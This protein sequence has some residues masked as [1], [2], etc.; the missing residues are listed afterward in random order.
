MKATTTDTCCNAMRAACLPACLLACL[1]A[2]LPE[3]VHVCV[4][5]RVHVSRGRGPLIPSLWLVKLH[6]CVC[7]CV[8][9]PSI[10]GSVG[11]LHAVCLPANPRGGWRMSTFVHATDALAPT[12]PLPCVDARLIGAYNRASRVAFVSFSSP[13]CLSVCPS[14]TVC[15]PLR[16]AVFQRER[17]THTVADRQTDRDRLNTN[18]SVCLSVC[19]FVVGQV[20]LHRGVWCAYPS[21]TRQ[22]TA[23]HG[24]AFSCSCRPAVP[25]F[26]DGWMWCVRR[27]LVSVWAAIGHTHTHTRTRTHTHTH[28]GEQ[29]PKGRDAVFHSCAEPVCR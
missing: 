5:V 25:T 28:T 14:A 23:R 1:P 26:S 17:G 13:V 6:V 27:L 9:Y 16:S 21:L 7:V 12:T 20:L 22:L 10:L 18:L 3:V 29:A 15:V 8:C 11:G 19:W 24:M 2:C 4:G